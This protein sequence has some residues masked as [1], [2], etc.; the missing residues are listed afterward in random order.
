MQCMFPEK[1][2]DIE[3]IRDLF[4]SWMVSASQQ[5][6]GSTLLRSG[7]KSVPAVLF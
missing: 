1:I 2:R 5:L 6:Q 4:T 7:C 3:G